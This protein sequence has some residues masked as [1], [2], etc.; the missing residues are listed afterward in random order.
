MFVSIIE[1]SSVELEADSE[2]YSKYYTSHLQ[3]LLI[4]IQ[5]E[6]QFLVLQWY[7]TNFMNLYWRG[8][9]KFY[10]YTMNIFH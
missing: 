10:F 6:L 1:T 5:F 8:V 4:V 9:C 3:E 7:L 2:R